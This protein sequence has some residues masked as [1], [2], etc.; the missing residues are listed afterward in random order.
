MPEYNAPTDEERLSRLRILQSRLTGDESTDLAW[1]LD[2]IY[3]PWVPALLHDMR[4]NEERNCDAALEVPAPGEVVERLGAWLTESPR[5]C[6]R[7]Q[8]LHDCPDD[9][10]GENELEKLL[11]RAVPHA[12]A[13]EVAEITRE[14]YEAHEEENPDA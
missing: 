4:A 8:L 14:Q 1:V 2:L 9:L 11:L 6:Y 5:R 10:P 7:V 3:A 13:V 12:E